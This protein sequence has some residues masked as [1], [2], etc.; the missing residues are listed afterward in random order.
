[1]ISC[2]PVRE[3][4]QTVALADSLLAEDNV[5]SDSSGIAQAVDALAPWQMFIPED[6]A[7]AC[8]YYGRLLRINEQY[9]DAAQ[10]LLRARRSL[11]GNHE[12]LGRTY[13]NLALICRWQGDY[14]LSYSLYEC[15]TEA[16]LN[17]GDT[18][19]YRIAVTNMAYALA[20]QGDTTGVQT[21]LAPLDSYPALA[22]M[23]N[24]TYAEAFMRAG[25]YKQGLHYAN[26]C[27][28]GEP[29]VMMIKGQCFSQSGQFDSATCYA[30][31]VLERSRH[32]FMRANALYILTQQDST[33]NLADVRNAAAERARV[34]NRIADKQG[35]L[36]RAVELIRLDINGRSWQWNLLLAGVLCIIVALIAWWQ[37]IRREHKRAI[38]HI[39]QQKQQAQEHVSLH[40]QQDAQL[41]LQ[42]A[43]RRKMIEQEVNTN[44][45]ALQRADTWRKSLGWYNDELFCEITN[46]QFFMLADKLKAHALNDKEIRLCML[47]LMDCFDSK[48]TAKLL[49]YAESGVRNFK[50]HTAN[51]LGT[52]SRELREHLI[53]IITGEC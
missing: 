16:F 50:Q 23:C 36:T 53:R 49:N 18:L 25:N 47:V 12:L 13:S 43:E 41:Q 8:F 11:T 48:Q 37:M 6:Y 20:E 2:T 7:K 52:T 21:L 31:K 14:P 42:I 5:Y 45:I 22:D 19:R 35:D 3:A 44:L 32:P 29:S 15:S 30:R 33:A 9:T 28:G 39:A 27:N 10:Y 24:E 40:Q 46:K 34:L 17:A 4:Q 38:A 51:K 1:M 26:R